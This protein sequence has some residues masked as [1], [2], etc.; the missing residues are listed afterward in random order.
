M[1]L[2]LMLAAAAAEAPICADRPTKANSV[3]TVP[4]GT[5]QV[6]SGLVSWSLTKVG[7]TRTTVLAVAQTTLKLGLTNTSD[8]EVGV[9][10]YA[11]VRV[12]HGGSVSGFGDMI[13]RY[14]RRLT[15]E[16]AVVQAAVIPFVKIPTA[17]HGLGNGKAEGG[18]AVPISFVIAGPATITLGPEADL[19]ADDDGEGRHVAVVNLVNVAGPIAPRLTL[20][21]EL[22][23]NLNF[24][25]ANTVRQA[26]ADAALSFA[27]SNDIQLDAGMNFGL[28]RATTDIEVYAG[29]SMRF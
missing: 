4:P 21:G 23:S 14:K 8:I 10:P 15:G 22:W 18:L 20:A 1:S 17:S 25:P 26:S 12:K 29:A 24:D 16:S 5:L 19:L 6:E 11:K 9:T 3:C 28:T 7:G 13:V 27:A 2:L